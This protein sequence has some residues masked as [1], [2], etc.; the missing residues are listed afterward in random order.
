MSRLKE[1]RI[2]RA[3]FSL[4]MTPEQCTMALTTAYRYEVEYRHR[5]Y[6][7][8]AHTK[9]IIGNVASWLCDKDKSHFGLMFCGGTGNG[10]TTM[11]CAIKSLYE[12]LTSNEPPSER[13][14]FIAL[15]ATE[16]NNLAKNNI[17][18]YKSVCMTPLLIIDDLGQEP[19][20]VLDYGN[21]INPTID[22]L[23]KRYTEQLFTIITTNLAPKQIRE[24]YGDRIADRFNEMVK[25]FI[26]SRDTFRL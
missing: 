12:F 19:A 10:K 25:K 5:N 23:A 1:R 7:D 21:V 15:P 24:K 8:D 17:D 18:R 26:F 11:A 4:P 14:R 13:K 3:R 22:L 6:C 9:P 16:I 20:E 2:T